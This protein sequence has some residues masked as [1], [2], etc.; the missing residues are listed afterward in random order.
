M[1]RLESRMKSH[2]DYFVRSFQE[3]KQ[4]K[5]KIDS[6]LKKETELRKEHLNLQRTVRLLKTAYDTQVREVKKRLTDHNERLCDLE[7]RAAETDKRLS[8]LEYFLPLQVYSEFPERYYKKATPTEFEA[9][10]LEFDW[11]TIQP[12]IIQKTAEKNGNFY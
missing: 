3:T 2:K 7:L 1:I 5:E 9:A 10:S 8:W 11:T 4:M 12:S 6:Q